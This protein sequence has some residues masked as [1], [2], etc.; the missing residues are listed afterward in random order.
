MTKLDQI[1]NMNKPSGWT[2]FDVVNK[3]RRTLK[4]KKVGH[5]G[6]LDPFATGVLIVLTGKNTKR[7]SE[8]MG[9]VKHY[10]ATLQLGQSSTTG[11]PEGEIETGYPLPQVGD[12]ELLEVL[13]SF[14]GVI[15]QIPPMYS[16]KKVNGR[17]LYE[18]A[19]KGQEIQ[20]EPVPVTIHDVTL[21]ERGIDWLKISVRCG[22]GTYI[23]V[24][25]EDIGARL[26]SAAYLTALERRA[27][28]DFRIEDAMGI[29][30][31]VD[32][33]KSFAA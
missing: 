20:R 22:K 17:K 21:L 10:T 33:W 28:G 8:F 1:L 5:A 27:V 32:R 18:L 24:L 9:L 11:D 29:E 7:Q 25:A 2:S 31:F 23:R 3:V 4:V 15:Q 14:Q 12:Q 19:R 30:E 26:E 13:Q 6:T 16:A